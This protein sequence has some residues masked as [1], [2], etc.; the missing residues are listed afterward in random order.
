MGLTFVP[1]SGRCGTLPLSKK[2]APNG[3]TST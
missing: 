2:G 3:T 1:I